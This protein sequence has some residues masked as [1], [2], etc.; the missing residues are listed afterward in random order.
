MLKECN[1]KKKLKTVIYKVDRKKLKKDENLDSMR[2][3][4]IVKDEEDL[5]MTEEV[6]KDGSKLN[7]IKKKLK[8]KILPNNFTKAPL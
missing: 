3:N 7:Q 2:M 6:S 8:T 1:L 5:I 4:L